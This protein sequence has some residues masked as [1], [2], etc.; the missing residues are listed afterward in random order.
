MTADLLQQLRDDVASGAVQLDE[1]VTQ[2]A[3]LDCESEIAALIGGRTCIE[4]SAVARAFAAGSQEPVA[5]L[6][7]AAGLSVNGYSA[8]LRMR[9]RSGR[10]L[11]G[12]VSALLGAYQ[13]RPKFT[14]VQLADS[15]QRYADEI[16]ECP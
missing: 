5:L 15:L 13:S 4:V 12:S 3:D 16:A 8:V 2:L 1:A 11:G 10:S 9:R 14:R 6:C 7:R